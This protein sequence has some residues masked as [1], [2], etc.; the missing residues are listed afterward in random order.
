MAAE[1]DDPDGE[2]NI[3][4]C[5]NTGSVIW[6]VQRVI[7]RFRNGAEDSIA[8]YAA[9]LARPVGTEGGQ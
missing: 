8:V 2:I 6:P 5:L 9:L 4:L 3:R 7:K 1:D